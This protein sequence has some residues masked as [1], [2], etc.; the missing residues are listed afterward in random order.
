M[1]KLLLIFVLLV[2][3]SNYAQKLS[4]EDGKFYKTG[5][6]ISKK[7]VK[8]LLESNT[9]ALE[10]YKTSKDKSAFGG[11][12]LGFGGGLIAA[13]LA[14]ALF[15]DIKYPTAATYIG[16]GSVVI[17]IPILIGRNKKMNKA[18][19]LYNSNIGSTGFND[20]FQ[21]DFVTNKNGVG[22]KFEF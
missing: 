21:L 9:Q 4:Y 8:K 20:N 5:V 7:E 16:I 18:I 17:S 12:L 6:P 3:C 15:S 19:E 11:F 2:S 10:L 22:L 13:D 1:K 14:T